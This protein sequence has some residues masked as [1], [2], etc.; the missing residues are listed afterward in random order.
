MGG[1]TTLVEGSR[2]GFDMIGNDLNPI[3][4]FVCRNE[5]SCSDP[6]TVRAFFNKLED[7][8]KPLVQPYYTTTCPRGHKGS[9]I[10]KDTGQK[11][12]IDPLNVPVEQRKRYQW[13]GPEVIY[14]FWAKHG[15]CQAEGCGHR[16]PIF[17]SPV[18]AQKNLSTQIIKAICPDCGQEFNIELGETRVAP[19]AERIILDSEPAFTETTQECG[20]LLKDYSKGNG[21]A[22]SERVGR[23]L[24]L[25]NDEPGLKCPGC[26]AFAGQQIKN[27][28]D[29]HS[30]AKR[31]SDI[32]KKD[33]SIEKRKIQMYLLISPEWL[34]GAAGI[35]ADGNELGGWAG[36]QPEDTEKWYKARLEGLDVTEVRGE[37]L[38]DKLTLPTGVT[39]KTDMTTIPK[40]GQFRCEKCGRSQSRLDA[41]KALKHSS[42]VSGCT[43]QC[44]CPECK[45]KLSH[46]CLFPKPR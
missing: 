46:F 5:L 31:V 36:A 40:Q 15:P 43:L 11:A 8:V 1:G 16:T 25:V 10:D 32:N 24:D 45:C 9:W 19:G 29:R 23:L 34:K 14:T 21:S 13:H 6:D 2:L 30:I 38:P 27:I 17:S 3:A 37:T 35:D 20:Q 4:W 44:Y 33:F 18:I 26:N 39:V 42:P 22:K 7:E 12:D 28:L 41:N